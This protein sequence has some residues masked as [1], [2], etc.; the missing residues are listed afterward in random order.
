MFRA[1]RGEAKVMPDKPLVALSSPF[2]HLHTTLGFPG[3]AGV[4]N[5]PAN[6]GD[7]G[8]AGSIPGSG[9]SPGVG[10]AMC[11][12]IAAQKFP[13]SEE[14]GRPQSKVLQGVGHD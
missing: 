4:K 11:S 3:G 6:T 14:P 2:T 5:P 10:M 1:T 7:T 8:D 13:G 9:R 12:S